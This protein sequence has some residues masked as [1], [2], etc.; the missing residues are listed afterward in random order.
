MLLSHGNAAPV[1][2]SNARAGAEVGITLNFEVCTPASPSGAD[3]DAARHADGS[4]NRWFLDALSG[5]RYPAD[6]VAD[7]ASAGAWEGAD[8]GWIH[9]G[10]FER[11][12]VPLDFVGL[13]YYTRKII[14]SIR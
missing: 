7:Y 3:R 6:I 14:R 9:D 13:N 11:I 1:I 5:R 10:D 4:F 8:G 12:A 2:R